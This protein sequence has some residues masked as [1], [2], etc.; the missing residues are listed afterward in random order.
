VCR[1][2]A[3]ANAFS[4]I[5]APR[6]SAAQLAGLYFH[7][8]HLKLIWLSVSETQE[9]RTKRKTEY[10][11]PAAARKAR[12][13]EENF[14]GTYNNICFAGAERCIHNPPRSNVKIPVLYVKTLYCNVSDRYYPSP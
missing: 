11:Y 5:P 14:R 12:I 1:N 3:E 2:H 7:D 6:P 8:I 4:P 9:N 10:L 13:F